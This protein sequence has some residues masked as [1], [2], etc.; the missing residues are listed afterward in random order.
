MSIKNYYLLGSE[1]NNTPKFENESRSKGLLSELEIA[2][3]E[4][5]KQRYNYDSVMYNN[6]KNKIVEKARNYY[7]NFLV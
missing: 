2:L 3:E 6:I 4:L 5:E 7:N 1:I